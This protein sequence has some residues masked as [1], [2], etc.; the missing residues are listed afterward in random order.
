LRLALK[1]IFFVGLQRMVDVVL[2]VGTLNAV[3]WHH[4]FGD[5]VPQFLMAYAV[6]N[7]YF[8][9]RRASSDRPREPAGGAWPRSG[10]PCGAVRL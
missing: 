2:P 7:T 8:S 3:Y 9:E 5:A 6:D 1:N 4:Y 10:P